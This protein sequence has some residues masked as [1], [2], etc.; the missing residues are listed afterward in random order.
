[1]NLIKTTKSLPGFI[2]PQFNEIVDGSTVVVYKIITLCFII[3]ANGD[4]NPSKGQSTQEN[5][6]CDGEKE[7]T[8]DEGAYTTTEVKILPWSYYFQD[9]GIL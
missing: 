6:M 1:M 3:K 5:G 2:V 8:K 4:K 9:A 7:K